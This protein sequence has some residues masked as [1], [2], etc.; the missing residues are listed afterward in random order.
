MKCESVKFSAWGRETVGVFEKHY[1]ANNGSFAIQVL[2]LCED[3]SFF[4]PYC[5]LTV[6]HGLPHPLPANCA[7]V[8]VNNCPEDLI[9]KLEEI[10]AMTE[11]DTHVRS[12]YVVYPLYKFNEEWLN[13]MS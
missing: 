7:F 2:S 8:D 13:T 10:G 4:E 9:R 6:N 1:Y 11:T 5:S 12:G 3:D